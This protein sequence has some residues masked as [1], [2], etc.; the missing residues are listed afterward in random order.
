MQYITRPLY[1]QSIKLNGL[2][3]RIELL[4]NDDSDH[5]ATTGT[6]LN[7]TT[8]T[9][10][11]TIETINDN[12]KPKPKRKEVPN[13]IINELEL[14]NSG[15]KLIDRRELT[16]DLQKHGREFPLVEFHS[17]ICDRFAFRSPLNSILLHTKCD[18]YVVLLSY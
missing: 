16:P 2:V 11:N 13:I 12:K 8:G 1:I 4:A 17:F 6:S 15:F 18:G 5:N 3:G 7:T 14:H 9:S 10:L